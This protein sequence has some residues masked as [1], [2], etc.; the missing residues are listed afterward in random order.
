MLSAIGAMTDVVEGAPV[1]LLRCLTPE[2]IMLIARPKYL[3]APG[4]VKLWTD[5]VATAYC[6]LLTRLREAR[7]ALPDD[8]HPAVD[9]RG[10]V[11]YG[12]SDSAARGG[13]ERPRGV[14]DLVRRGHLFA[15]MP[16]GD[17]ASTHSDA[18]MGETGR[19]LLV[20]HLGSGTS[21]GP[22]SDDELDFAVRRRSSSTASVGSRPR[23]RS[24]SRTVG[25]VTLHG[26]LQGSAGQE[27]LR[28][29]ASPGLDPS[30]GS[31]AG[32]GS[33]AT[34]V[35]PPPPRSPCR[36]MYQGGW[37]E[38]T[39]VANPGLSTLVRISGTHGRPVHV[40]VLRIADPPQLRW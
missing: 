40:K 32:R 14:G 5:D 29:S 25:A 15:A 20:R 1:A 10:G 30:P 18:A 36:V 11:E 8:D 23:S 17:A 12:D 38:G 27:A 6:H 28:E 21:M 4:G 26:T 13:G 2:S 7:A 34:I 37:V 22:S 33:P 39:V 3:E 19:K 16:N 35:G 31:R 24:G 9:G